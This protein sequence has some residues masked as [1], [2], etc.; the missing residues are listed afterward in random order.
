MSRIKAVLIDLDG[1]LV[2]S[3]HLYLEANI[4]YFRR[5]NKKFTVEMHRQGTGKKFDIWIR[6]IFPDINKSG[7]EILEGRNAI[8]FE[9]AEERLELLPGALEFLN[10]VSVNFKNALVTSSRQDYLD[11]VYRRTGI[12]TC[13]DV[14]VDGSMVKNGKPEPESYLLAAE[15][16]DV[17]KKS[18]LVFEDSP[19]GVKAGLAASMLVVNIPSQFVKG[20]RLLNKASY[21]FSSLSEVKLNWIKSL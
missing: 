21:K 15:R 19:A 6:T 3:E 13:F 5:L 8:F 11:I 2:N 16:L 7:E 12:N 17:D 14:V 9:L 1:L 20:D 18:C 4:I 10:I